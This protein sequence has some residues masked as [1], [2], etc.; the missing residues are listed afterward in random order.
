V[1]LPLAFAFLVVIPEPD[2]LLLSLLLLRSLAF[3]FAFL[4]V[5]FLSLPFYK[6][7]PS[8]KQLNPLPLLL[9]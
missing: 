5:S 8:A 6:R 3:V 2:L 1:I 4:C 7:S 9:Q